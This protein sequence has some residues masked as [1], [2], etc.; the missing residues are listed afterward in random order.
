MPRIV[1]SEPEA[2]DIAEQGLG[3]SSRFQTGMG[4]HTITSGLEGAWTPTPTTWDNGYFDM[5]FDYE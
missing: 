2:G 1:G 5:L 3:W 4:D